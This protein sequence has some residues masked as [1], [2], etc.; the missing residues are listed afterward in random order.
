M[1]SL[2]ESISGQLDDN[3]SLAELARLMGGDA[4]Q[5]KTA[6]G[7][8]VPAILGALAD[9][10]TADGP[11]AVAAILDGDD[12][13]A[14]DDPL[15][16][17]HRGNARPG[18]GIL[19]AVFGPDRA[20]LIGGLAA[21]AGVADPMIDRVLPMV[22]PLAVGVVAKRR[23]DDG[24]NDV[25]LV[26]LLTS[27]K[28]ALDRTGLLTT[29]TQGSTTE[30]TGA[31]EA[32]TEQAAILASAPMDEPAD[33]A[34]DKPRRS[35][36]GRPRS[37]RSGGGLGWLWWAI[38]AVIL[39]LLLAWLLSMCTT[40]ADAVGGAGNTADNTA[41][42]SAA[43]EQAAEPDP[44]AAADLASATTITD[45]DQLLQADID[46]ALAGTGVNGSVTDGVVTLTGTV[47]SDAA[48]AEL[49]G[50]IGAMFGVMVVD[51]NTASA[52]DDPQSENADGQTDADT[53]TGTGLDGG[54]TG[55]APASGSTIN[56]LL[57]L[58]PVTFAI[59]SANV[60]PEGR[61]VL[62]EAAGFMRANPSV[63]I[64]IGGH[65]DDDGPES[66]NQV[67]SQNRADAVRRYLEQ[68]GIDGD[69]MTSRGYG[70]SVPLVPNDS[71]AA[72]AENRRIEFTIL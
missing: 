42:N 61:S 33:K 12:G 29:S 16:F 7:V 3:S 48:S 20:A 44:P 68:T 6:T 67:L 57:D 58:D 18:T 30:A 13:V 38:G 1:P 62:D 60:T 63:N 54:S 69:R 37:T 4:A 21:K 32:S 11:A 23:N 15:G 28:E 64:E 41:G 56:Q 25:G 31:A 72:K 43:G 9:R 55:E 17:L 70:E 19:D 5:A 47:E 36:D 46:R 71:S 53:E 66:E 2:L 10:A 24:L 39:V 51:N 27:E 59:S 45:L 8:T 26:E 52:T 40:E 35:A 14:V 49:E 50:L 22:A 65:T 34:D